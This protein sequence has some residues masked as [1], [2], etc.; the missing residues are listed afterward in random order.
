[1]VEPLFIDPRDH[2]DTEL[3]SRI[4]DAHAN[5]T[6][7]VLLMTLGRAC[8]VCLRELGAADNCVACVTPKTFR[9]D[10]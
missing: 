4:R 5:G 3:G 7:V 1:M 10:A 8:P 6:R 2:D 9:S